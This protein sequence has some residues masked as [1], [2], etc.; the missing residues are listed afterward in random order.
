MRG[1]RRSPISSPDR[2]ATPDGRRA[3]ARDA[4]LFTDGDVVKATSGPTRSA[5]LFGSALPLGEPV[6]WGGPIVMNTR[7][8]LRKA[9]EDIDNG[10]FLK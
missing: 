5:L 3:K 9:F 10:T 7:E 8:E 1:K 6:A 4:A 2:F